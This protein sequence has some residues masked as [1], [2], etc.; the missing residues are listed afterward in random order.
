MSA[1]EPQLR[2]LKLKFEPISGLSIS[3]CSELK[4]F[5]YI[6]GMIYHFDKLE[7]DVDQGVIKY[8]NDTGFFYLPECTHGALYAI[9]LFC[10]INMDDKVPKLVRYQLYS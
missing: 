10:D 4:Y 6:G 1:K 8:T 9:E 2:D 7:D 3:V 5:R